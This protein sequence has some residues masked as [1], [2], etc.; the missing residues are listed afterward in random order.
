MVDSTVP[1]H[2]GGKM[3][4]SE[5]IDKYLDLVKRWKICEI[6]EWQRY[7]FWLARLQQFL[8]ALK[9]KWRNRKSEEESRPYRSPYC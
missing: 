9:R 5:K 1:V 2:Y 8:K 3:N 6:W 7:Q 4:E